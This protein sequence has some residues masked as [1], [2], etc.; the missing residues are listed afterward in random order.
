M[1]GVVEVVAR[2]L[3]TVVGPGLP[4]ATRQSDEHRRARGT[5]PALDARIGWKF[6]PIHDA[7]HEPLSHRGYHRPARQEHNGE[8]ET[9]FIRS[10]WL[11]AGFQ[12]AAGAALALL[13]VVLLS[14]FLGFLAVLT[15]IG[16][17]RVLK[18]ARL[19]ADVRATAEQPLPDS[20]PDATLRLMVRIVEDV[21]MTLGGGRNAK[22]REAIVRTV[23][24]RLRP[25][26][27]ALATLG[28][29]FTYGGAFVVAF[30]G[31]VFIAI[32]QSRR[33]A[34]RGAGS[35]PLA[36]PRRDSRVTARARPPPSGLTDELPS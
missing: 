19:A 30:I 29:L 31:A 8:L 17:P 35:Q 5:I 23:F 24:E 36:S 27:R 25:P 7:V 32:A 9:V 26:P 2:R 21:D 12:V 10:R 13:A 28:L 14:P 4:H 3:V 1:G 18:I 16:A 20:M 15:V 6:L 11:E 34:P 22:D 33:S